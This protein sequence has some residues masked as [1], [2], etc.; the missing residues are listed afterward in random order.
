MYAVHVF[1]GMLKV[2]GWEMPLRRI[3]LWTRCAAS[4]LTSKAVDSKREETRVL[5]RLFYL[6]SIKIY[7]EAEVSLGL[8]WP[9]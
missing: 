7:G 8:R 1:S 5:E 4:S 9:S 6:N 2:V 3:L